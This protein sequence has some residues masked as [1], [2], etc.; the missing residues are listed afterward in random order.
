MSETIA[1][2]F[3]QRPLPHTVLSVIFVIL[4]IMSWRFGY[5]EVVESLK[6]QSGWIVVAG[7]LFLGMASFGLL[8]WEDEPAGD[9]ERYDGEER[10][11]SF[12]RS[13]P[14]PPPA[15]L[16]RCQSDPEVDIADAAADEGVDK[17]CKIV[18][19]A[20]EET[21]LLVGL[22]N[23][24]E[25]DLEVI[26]IKA[27]VHLPFDHRLLVQNLSAQVADCSALQGFWNSTVSASAQ[28]TFPYIFAV[29]KYLQ[30]GIFDLVG[31]IIYEIDQVPYQS[32]FYNGTIEVVEVGGFLSMESVFLA[33]LGI[34]LLVLLGLWIHGRIRQLSKKTKRTPKVEVGT[35][36]TDASLDEWLQGTAY[37]QFGSIKKKKK[38]ELPEWLLPCQS[39]RMPHRVGGMLF[40]PVER[41]TVQSSI[42]LILIVWH[43]G[44]GDEFNKA[45]VE[46]VG[47]V[48]CFDCA[49]KKVFPHEAF[50]GIGVTVDCKEGNEQFKTRGVGLLNGEGKFWVFLPREILLENGN[51]KEECFIHLHSA[52]AT[53]CT[54]LDGIEATRIVLK[55]KIDEKYTF[56]PAGN[57]LTVQP[58]WVIEAEAA[59][60]DERRSLS[61]PRE[62]RLGCFLGG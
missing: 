32:T 37:T 40:E 52:S 15:G 38:H 58:G 27:S 13:W 59:K 50:S 61:K 17:Y 14:A 1:K 22:K 34:A 41:S 29:S 46:V 43:L 11:V 42:G 60:W 45:E 5:E 7:A 25:S 36:T 33:T 28:A 31:T 55:S 26:A 21:E 54:P 2:G 39:H 24:E 30:A 3:S 6:V 18:V 8:G 9:E 47:L 35:G 53:P 16:S 20:G 4:L 51:L 49:I 44:L 19:P 12:P 23:N 56:G 57:D 10:D 48:D 62:C